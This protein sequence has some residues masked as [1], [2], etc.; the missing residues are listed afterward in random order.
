MEGM[1][2]HTKPGGMD[3]GADEQA[4]GGSGEQPTDAAV[5]LHGGRRQRWGRTDCG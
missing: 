2:L 1:V 4:D 5:V 3:R